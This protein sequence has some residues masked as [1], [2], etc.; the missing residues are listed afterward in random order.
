MDR[1]SMS[2][3]CTFL[4]G[5]LVS[6]RSKKQ[7]VVARSSAGAKYRLMAQGVCEVLWLKR[8]LNELKRPNNFPMKLYC[9]NKSA[10]SI[11]YNPVQHDKTKH[12]EINMDFIEEKL[13]EGVI[14]TP[15]VP[16]TK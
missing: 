5:N 2:R 8:V 14:C 6:W 15:F 1:R 16:T 11:A 3:Y 9:D 12:I 4:W 10:I 7:S 13:E